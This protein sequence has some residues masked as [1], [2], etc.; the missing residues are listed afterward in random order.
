MSYQKLCDWVSVSGLT[1]ALEPVTER[2]CKGCNEN[3]DQCKFWHTISQVEDTICAVG[4]EAMK[5][6]ARE[7][8]KS[9][10]KGQVQGA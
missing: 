6:V 8:V 3:C 2:F 4:L 9:H 5:T 7:W 10:A 1:R